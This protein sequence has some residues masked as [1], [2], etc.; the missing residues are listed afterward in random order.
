MD[1]E[2]DKVMVDETITADDKTTVIDV[3]DAPIITETVTTEDL[4]ERIL[5][6]KIATVEEYLKTVMDRQ[7]LVLEALNNIQSKLSLELRTDPIVSEYD[8]LLK[9]YLVV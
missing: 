4:D 3:P 8:R 1:K 7:V 9:D 2:D 5:A 6:S